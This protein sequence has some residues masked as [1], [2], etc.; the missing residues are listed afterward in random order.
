[1]HRHLA[2]AFLFLVPSSAAAEISVQEA[3]LRA[4]PAVALVVAEVSAEVVVLCGGGPEKKIS[5]APFRETG[6]GWFLNPSGWV[7]TNG[8]VVSPPPR[9][10]KTVAEP[11]A[12]AA[13]REA[14]GNLS[15]QAGG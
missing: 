3:L 15:P 6:T 14:C 13:V 8:P 7:I 2:L 4:K 9:P 11:Q 5:P 1:M 12:R 10:P